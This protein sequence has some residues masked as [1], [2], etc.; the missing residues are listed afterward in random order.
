MT[1]CPDKQRATADPKLDPELATKLTDQLAAETV[2]GHAPIHDRSANLRT[3]S[4][5]ARVEKTFS[6]GRPL[7]SA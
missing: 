7:W 6:D 4:D 3:K 2:H 5:P 1:R